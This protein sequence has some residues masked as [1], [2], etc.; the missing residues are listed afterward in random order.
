MF[1][2]ITGG[3]FAFHATAVLLCIL[4]PVDPVME[5]AVEKFRFRR[6]KTV[7]DIIGP[8][9]FWNQV[10]EIFSLCET[11]ELRFV[12][13]TYIQNEIC[14][15]LQNFI[16]KFACRRLISADFKQ[17]ARCPHLRFCP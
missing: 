7:V 11:A 10:S 16:K 8:T 5:I 12:F 9:D 2:K 3:V 15:V 17:I 14:V 1:Q 4:V 13:K 6:K